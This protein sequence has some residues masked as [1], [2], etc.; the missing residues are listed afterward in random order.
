[1]WP[2]EPARAGW[3]F[4]K[5]QKTRIQKQPP[6]HHPSSRPRSV[7]A[8]AVVRAVVAVPADAAVVA[9]ADEAG[10]VPV[11]DVARQAAG[12]VVVAVLAATAADVAARGAVDGVK[13]KAVTAT[14]DAA[15][16]EA[17][18]SRT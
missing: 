12:R 11:A 1:V 3:S 7:H 2:T 4:N 18:S 5:W 10:P 8:Q 14:A 6:Q 17:S 15:M 9:V 13:A 16:V